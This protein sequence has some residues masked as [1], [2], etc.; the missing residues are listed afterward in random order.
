MTAPITHPITLKLTDIPG[1]PLFG[2][3]SGPDWALAVGVGKRGVVIAGAGVVFPTTGVEVDE[4]EVDGTGVIGG[5]VP[6]GSPPSAH[7]E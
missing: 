2:E 6:I 1:V 3:V 4:V 7:A 5:G